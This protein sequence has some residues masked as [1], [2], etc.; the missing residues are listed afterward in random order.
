MATMS[1]TYRNLIAYAG[2]LLV[3]HIGLV[4]ELGAELSGGDPAYARQAV[5]WT[6]PSGGTIRPTADL[7]FNVPAG[8]I[9]AGWHGFSALTEGIDYGGKE[10]DEEAFTN[11]GQY[12]LL[13]AST[14]IKHE[15]P[16]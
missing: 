13:C 12:K 9:V 3:T 10:L 1:E 6:D 14:G 11:Q 4:D 7:T 8:R 5:T 15:N 16:A 2:G